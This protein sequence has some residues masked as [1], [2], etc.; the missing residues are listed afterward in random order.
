MP[1]P[2]RLISPIDGRA[3]FDQAISVGGLMAGWERVRGNGGSAGGDGVSIAVFAQRAGER[4]AGLSVALREG[5]Y[6]PGPLRYASIPKASGGLRGLKIPCVADR[7]VQSSRRAGARATARR[8]I[9][10]FQF[11]LSRRPVRGRRSA[12]GGILAPAGFVWT[13]DADIDDFFD[14]IPIDALMTQFGK[15]VT[16]GPLTDLVAVWLEQGA[17]QG[18][19]IAQGSPLSPLLANL[20]LNSLDEEFSRGGL[21]IVR[22]ADDFVVLAK[23]RPA[24]EAALTQVRE[25]LARHGLRL[26]AEK[27]RLATYDDTL[28]FLGHIFVRGWALPDPKGETSDGVQAALRRLEEGDIGA[29]K[30]AERVAADEA[31]QSSAGYDRAMR[32]LHLHA[33][34]RRLGLRNEAFAVF[35]APVKGLDSGPELI[36]VHHSRIDRIEI[37]PQAQTDLATMRH[38]LACAIPVAFVDGHGRPAGWLAPALGQHAGRHLAQARHALDAGLRLDLARRL[39]AGRLANE[40]SLLRR[41]NHRRGIAF[42]SRAAAIVGRALARAEAAQSLQEV[43][44]YEGAGTRT[45]WKAWGRLLLNEFSFRTRLRRA[46]S[47]PVNIALDM[48]SWLLA[49]DLAAIVAASGLHP[50]FG[51]LHA[52]SDYRDGCVYDLMEE[53]RAGLVESVVL[54]MINGGALRPEM[55]SIAEDGTQ[56]LGRA[57][58]ETIIRRYESRCDNLVTSLRGGRR[59][60]WRRLMR[61]QAEAYAAHVEGKAIY[62]PYVLDN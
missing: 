29:Q 40:R 1:V 16:D 20:Y 62:R 26:D 33:P 15:S 61:E 59:V 17:V 32:V 56:R 7:V 58:S 9:R 2:H 30:E 3:V 19:G 54:A 41:I 43:M 39:V 34:G 52:S 47:D 37:G 8:G 14:T 50:G 11:R 42:V 60:T 31:Q 24:A 57:G 4:L 51:T 49:R 45:Y 25:L 12:P 53:F 46:G 21:R 36:A 55:F 10:G 18:R 48:A 5:R 35:E 23:A 22:Y 13:L 44:G 27:T 6:R 28:R 38:A